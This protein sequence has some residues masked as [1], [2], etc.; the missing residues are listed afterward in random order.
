MDDHV[1]RILEGAKAWNAWRGEQRYPLSFTT[2]NWYKG[3]TKGQ[4]LFDFSEINLSDITIYNAFAEGLN[5]S[6]GIFHRTH[7]EEGDFSRAD[8]SNAVF[9]DTK[10]N[11][12]ILT[13]ANFEGASF[14]NCNLNRVNLTQA[15]FCVKEIRDTVVY[16]ISAWDLLTCDDMQQS[17]LVIERTYDLYSDLISNGRIPLSVDNIELAQFIH[18]LS[19]HKKMRDT[20]NIL[21]AKGVLLLG[22]FND[23]GL[24]R[25]YKLREWLQQKGYMPMIFDFAR[26]DSLDLTETIITMSGLSKFIVADLS[27]GSVPHELYAINSNFRKPVVAYSKGSAYAMFHDLKRKNPYL[28]SFEIDQDDDIIAKLHAMLPEVEEFSRK[29][30]LELGD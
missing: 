22:R 17:N 3:L 24:E 6:G 16:G 10:F 30:V 28:V 12:T 29:I 20:L 14:V 21:N 1:T 9:V 7:F 23:G 15:N 19:N 5:L 26:P 25:L 8:F 27:G 18:Y 4:N 2:P 11:K 13:N